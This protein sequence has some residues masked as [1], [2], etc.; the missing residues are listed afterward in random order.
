MTN[1]NFHPDIILE[2]IRN[3]L[4]EPSLVVALDSRLEEDLGFDST[5]MI[6]VIIDIEKAL[7]SSLA[8]IHHAD[9]ETVEDMV[10][11]VADFISANRDAPV[12]A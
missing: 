4:G 3:F 7:G 5:E 1:A 8:G 10:R 6:S 9:M 2:T 11:G 12:P